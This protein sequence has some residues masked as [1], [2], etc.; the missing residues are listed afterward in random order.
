M[1]DIDRRY[2]G[3]EGI[4]KNIDHIAIIFSIVMVLL[5]DLAASTL[6]DVH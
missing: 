5:V 1:S 2:A 4:G 3:K 6:G